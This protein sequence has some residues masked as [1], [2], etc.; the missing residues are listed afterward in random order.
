MDD[1]LYWLSETFLPVAKNFFLKFTPIHSHPQFSSF[2]FAVLLLQQNCVKIKAFY[3]ELCEISKNTFFYRTPPV[4]TSVGAEY[5]VKRISNWVVRVQYKS[6]RWQMFFKIGV[7]PA[8]LLRRDSNTGSFLLNLRNFLKHLFLRTPV[9][10]RLLLAV[11]SIKK[12]KHTL[13]VYAAEKEMIY[14]NGTS[15]VNVSR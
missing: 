7:R 15:K 14:L 10:Q 13:K 1:V 11:N 8:N 2:F 12:W 3:L 4:A 6:S 5:K 9:L